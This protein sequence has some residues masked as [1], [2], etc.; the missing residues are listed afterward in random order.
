M[1]IVMVVVMHVI[2]IATRQ[3]F[4]LT[5]DTDGD[6]SGNFPE[7]FYGIDPLDPAEHLLCTGV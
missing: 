7:L 2:S 3:A 4:K 5:G 1:H 6:K